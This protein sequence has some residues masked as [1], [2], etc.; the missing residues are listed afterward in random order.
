V[1]GILLNVQLLDYEGHARARARYRAFK[2]R[3]NSTNV[4][5]STHSRNFQVRDLVLP[6]ALVLFV[7]Q[8]TC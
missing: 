7:L 8:L 4:F 5:K 1:N 3:E 2:G 6:L